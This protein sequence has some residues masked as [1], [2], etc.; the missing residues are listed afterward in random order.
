MIPKSSMIQRKFELEAWTLIIQKSM[1]IPP[2]SIVLLFWGLAGHEYILG[3]GWDSLCRGTVN[4]EK[5]LAGSGWV[6]SHTR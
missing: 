2:S 4:S 6:H 3:G 1:L 5:G